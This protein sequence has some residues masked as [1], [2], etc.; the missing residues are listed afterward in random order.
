MN[1]EFSE[2][3]LMLRDSVARFI[4]DNYGFDVRQAIARS[5]EGISRDN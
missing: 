3:Q 1:F 2:E 4:Q 5:Q